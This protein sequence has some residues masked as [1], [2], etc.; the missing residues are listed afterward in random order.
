MGHLWKKSS[1]KTLNFDCFA[2]YDLFDETKSQLSNYEIQEINLQEHIAKT[3]N[4]TMNI[5][6][7][8]ALIIFVIIY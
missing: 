5:C 1:A 8:N 7:M 6:T 4:I 2:S 3:V